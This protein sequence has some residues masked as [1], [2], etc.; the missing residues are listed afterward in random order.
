MIRSLFSD[1]KREMSDV[2]LVE[3]LRKNDESAL[4]HLYQQCFPQVQRFVKDNSGS[5]ADAE[6]VFQDG[7]IA[8]WEQVLSGRFELREDARV[9]TYVIRICTYRWYERL[10]SAGFRKTTALPALFDQ[11]EDAEQLSHLVREEQI[12][13]M[14]LKFGQ[15]N[16]KCRQILSLFYFDRKTMEEI[17]SIMGYQASSA[18]NEKYRCMEKFKTLFN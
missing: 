12:R 3:R 9:R 7:M 13:D 5:E 6:D 16:D 14:E 8:F 1:R 11:P 2:E 17:A 18:K 4:N 10:K 15:L